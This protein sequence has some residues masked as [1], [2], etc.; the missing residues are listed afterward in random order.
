MLIEEY[1]RI[2][3]YRDNGMY[4]FI[5]SGF[6][7]SDLGMIRREIDLKWTNYKSLAI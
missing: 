4:Y 5:G 1:R 7:A 3:I 6:T 2:N